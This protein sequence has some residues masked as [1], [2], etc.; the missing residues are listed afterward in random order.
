MGTRKWPRGTTGRVV[1]GLRPNPVEPTVLLPPWAG[2]MALV[3]RRVGSR[4]R[5]RDLHPS[6]SHAGSRDEGERRPR[7]KCQQG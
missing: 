6:S 1:R 4:P 5:V 3:L 7:E 2:N